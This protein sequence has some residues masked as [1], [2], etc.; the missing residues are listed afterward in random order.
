MG[1][2]CE[3]KTHVPDQA[4]SNKGKAHVADHT[5][6]SKSKETMI[7]LENGEEVDVAQYNNP[8]SLS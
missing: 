7:R 2:C 4:N 1:N 8:D 3:S 5:N 6:S